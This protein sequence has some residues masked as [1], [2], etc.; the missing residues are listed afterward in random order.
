ME[1]KIIEMAESL[2]KVRRLKEELKDKSYWIDKAAKETGFVPAEGDWIHVDVTLFKIVVGVHHEK[3][4]GTKYWFNGVW[5][6]DP[7][8][9]KHPLHEEMLSKMRAW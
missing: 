4:G 7:F 8:D 6:D 1:E 5:T 3:Y 9:S 2:I